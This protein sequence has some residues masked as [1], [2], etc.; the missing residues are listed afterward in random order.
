MNNMK[1]VAKLLGVELEEEFII[2][3]ARAHMHVG[4][5]IVAKLDKDGLQ[6]VG[7]SRNGISYDNPFY[8][9]RAL[10][11]LLVGACVIEHKPWKP[12][13]DEKY[14][15]IGTGGVLEP[16]VWLDDFIDITLYRLGNCYPTAE[17]ASANLAKWV[18]FCNSDEHI[19][20]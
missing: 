11:D 10:Q 5:Y 9:A 8:A 17:E 1:K 16:G 15:S 18:K 4:E 2:K 20:V 7:C 14:Y 12:K 13:Y 19:E 3:D 6:I